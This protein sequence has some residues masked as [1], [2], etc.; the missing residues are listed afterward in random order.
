VFSADDIFSDLVD[1]TRDRQALF[2][3][4]QRCIPEGEFVLVNAGNGACHG[5]QRAKLP[6]DIVRRLVQKVAADGGPAVRAFE[7]GGRIKAFAVDALDAV[8]IHAAPARSARQQEALAMM[9]IEAFLARKDLKTEQ[10]AAKTLRNQYE[11][12]L[13]VL[14][15]KYQEILEDNQRQNQLI[16]K[17][18]ADY[19]KTL[20]SEIERQTAELRQV[21]VHLVDAR[22]A[23]EKASQAK[24]DFLANMSHEIRTPMNGVLGMCGMLLDTDLSDEQHDMA[25]TIQI[26]AESLLEIINDILDFSKIEA[27]KIELEHVDFDLAAMVEDVS[28][29]MSL[30][31]HEKD[32]TYVCSIDPAIPPKL[33]GDPGRVRQILINLCGNAIKFT[34]AGEIVVRAALQKMHD[35]A[36]TVQFSV[37]DTGIGIPPDRMDKLFKSFSQ[38]D[39]ST[40]RRFGGTGL[41]LA[42]SKQLAQKMNGAIG[43]ESTPGRGSTFW[44]TA[45]FTKLSVP[46][47]RMPPL[48]GA[49]KRRILVVDPNQTVRAVLKEQLLFW[50][51]RYAGAASGGAALQRFQEGVAAADP[52]DC[53]LIDAHLPDMDAKALAD[54]LRQSASPGDVSLV[55]MRRVDKKS[56]RAAIPADRFMAMM[57]KPVKPKQLYQCLAG[58]LKIRQRGGR[59]PEQTT[60]E[61]PQA[62]LET[63]AKVRILLAED[64]AV[65]QKLAGA[66]LMK[67]GYRAEVVG[68]GVEVLK[69]LEAEP[70]DLVFMDCQMP[71]MDGYEATR[72]IR[73]SG[74]AYRDITIVAVTAHAS[75]SAREKCMAAGMD[76]YLTKPYKPADFSK[77]IRKW[78]VRPGRSG[79]RSSAGRP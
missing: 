66:V 79:M 52:F 45:V 2:E 20:Q 34:H 32:L 23:A 7:D 51:C 1:H 15:R 75:G 44:F 47:E 38:V 9:C 43:V 65:N 21:N 54:R 58:N 68:N 48:T 28:D 31:A 12:K 72:A 35:D 10:Q 14:Q 57:S 5:T 63:A 30:T 69:A 26:S 40:T 6:P 39:A 77:M 55:L 71:E 29:L 19:S 64:N 70:Y 74:A 18:Q 33:K 24:S 4:L 46:Y 50:Q 8:L 37:T 53:V 42:I 67:L 78:R 25:Q 27:G 16:Q 17:Q 11:R 59:P 62:A 56:Y 73:N 22:K 61:D 36:V 60:G 3:Q 76:D 13:A 49:P 41:G